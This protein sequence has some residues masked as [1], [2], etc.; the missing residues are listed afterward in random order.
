MN[1]RKIS[2]LTYDVKHRKTYDTL[3]LLKAKGYNNVTVYASPMKYKKK[4]KPWIIHRPS[5]NMD[6]PTIDVLCGNLDY[7]YVF[8]EKIDDRIPNDDIILLCG[9]GLLADS[10]VDSHKIINAHP[11][12]SPYCRGLDSLKWAIYDFKKL[13]VTTHLIGKYIDAGYIIEKR[14]ISIFENDDFYNLSMRVYENE[15][16]MLVGALE[17]YDIMSEFIEADN[18]N[19]YKRM[20][21]EIERKFENYFERYK[22]KFSNEKVNNDEKSNN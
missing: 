4:Y 11:G 17:K 12:L 5:L 1:N 22:E 3:C 20:P 13:G 10:F 15:I 18:K 19:V 16:D 8:I 9:A 2:V 7:K 14:E 21:N 6:I